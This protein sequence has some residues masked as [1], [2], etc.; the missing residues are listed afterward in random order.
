MST[1][2]DRLPRPTDIVPAGRRGQSIAAAVVVV[3]GLAVT[4]AHASTLDTS[5]NTVAT[6]LGPGAGA[7]FGVVLIGLTA[8]LF[9]GDLAAYLPSVAYWTVGG[10][11]VFGAVGQLFTL[12]RAAASGEPVTVGLL[13]WFLAAAGGLVGLCVGVYDATLRRAREELAAE[14]ERA[15]EMLERLSAT[16]RSLRNGVRDSVAEARERNPSPTTVSMSDDGTATRS[17]DDSTAAATPG[18]ANTVAS[19]ESPATR[20]STD[21]VDVV[22]RTVDHIRE[23]RPQASVELELPESVPTDAKPSIDIATKALVENAVEHG[24]E[25]HVSCQRDGDTVRLEV[26]DDGTGVPDDV[27]SALRDASD[28]SVSG[29]DGLWMANW[30]V[31]QS[32]GTLSFDTSSGTTATVELAAAE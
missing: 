6:V 22:Q 1:S 4:L 24:G 13:V 7:L 30:S 28:D 25:T 20:E 2:T 27:L 26:A 5:T 21:L 29:G 9:R 14:R 18:E 15:E 31:E 8:V 19:A 10:A 32:G 11:A 12:S 16:N 17:T 23:E 3:V